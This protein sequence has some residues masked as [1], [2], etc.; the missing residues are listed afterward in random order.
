MSLAAFAQGK[1]RKLTIGSHNNLEECQ[2]LLSEKNAW[3]VL[4]E[5][6]L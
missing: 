5:D 2:R 3:H 6:T 4:W 1:S